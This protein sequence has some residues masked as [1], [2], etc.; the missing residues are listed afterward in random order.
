MSSRW[1]ESDHSPPQLQAVQGI[2]CLLLHENH[3]VHHGELLLFHHLVAHLVP[4]VKALQLLVQ[5]AVHHLQVMPLPPQLLPPVVHGVLGGRGRTGGGGEH[6]EHLGHGAH[7]ELRP[8]LLPGPAPEPGLEGPHPSL[9]LLPLL[10]APGVGA[11]VRPGRRQEEGWGGEGVRGWLRGWPGLAQELQEDGRGYGNRGRKWGVLG[12]GG[13]QGDTVF[14][15]LED[16]GGTRRWS[17]PWRRWGT[18]WRGRWR[19][20]HHLVFGDFVRTVSSSGRRLGL[21]FHVYSR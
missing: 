5:L 3:L 17:A 18:G 9:L 6:G 20:G 10:Q 4:W 2:S 15:G 8:L 13:W 11:A 21:G 12:C 14:V 1:R 19:Q 7:G 16:G